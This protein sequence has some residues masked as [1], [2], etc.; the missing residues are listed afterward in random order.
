MYSITVYIQA[1]PE[2]RIDGNGRAKFTRPEE[3]KL[4]RTGKK[5]DKLIEKR[6]V[7]SLRDR[8]SKERK[9][10][11]RYIRTFSTRTFSTNVE[12]QAKWGERG[13]TERETKNFRSKFPK[14]PLFPPPPPLNLSEFWSRQEEEE[15]D[16][17]SINKSTK[18]SN[19]LPFPKEKI[20]NRFLSKNFIHSSSSEKFFFFFFLLLL[21]I[22][23]I[24]RGE[25]YSFSNK[26]QSQI[27][28]SIYLEFQNF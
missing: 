1:P 14:K 16:D 2:F 22:N 6:Y 10:E 13:E 19:P 9:E 27:L 21:A 25:I 18:K 7:L 17:K 20:P 28:T 3:V 11:T 12:C 5:F 8:R 24:Y 23:R 26:F 4:R 15:E